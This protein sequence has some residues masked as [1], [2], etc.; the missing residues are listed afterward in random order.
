VTG[1][2]EIARPG[3]AER[4]N[5][6]P[7]RY[8]WTETRV[9]HALLWVE[10]V[11]ATRDPPPEWSASV[12]HSAPAEIIQAGASEWGRRYLRG[13]PLR[14]KGPEGP[15]IAQAALRRLP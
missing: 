4:A 14:R 1:R 9:S 13:L 12:P 7:P 5:A 11:S 10:P 2:R 3:P 6:G 15:E 8:R